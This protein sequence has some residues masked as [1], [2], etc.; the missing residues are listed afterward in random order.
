MASNCR[1]WD[2]IFL[3]PILFRNK[4]HVGVWVTNVQYGAICMIL[5]EST[6]FLSSTMNVYTHPAIVQIF[7]NY[8]YTCNCTNKK[9]KSTRGRKLRFNLWV[10]KC[11]I[12]RVCYPHPVM[13]RVYYELIQPGLTNVLVRGVLDDILDKPQKALRQP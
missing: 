6:L 8:K 5:N 9:S 4:S 1:L 10:T 11:P 3:C 13:G 7:R 2:C 12:W